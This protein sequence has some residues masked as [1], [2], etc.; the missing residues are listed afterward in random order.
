[1]AIN[2]GLR[3]IRRLC[4]QQETYEWYKSKLSPLLFKP[5]EQPVFKW[6]DDF[7]RTHHALP[8]IDTLVKYFPAVADV[9]ATEVASYYVDLLEND[10]C[11]SKIVQ[12]GQDSANLLKEN[13][14]AWKPAAEIL[15][16]TLNDISRQ[17]YREKIMDFGAEAN[18]LLTKTYYGLEKVPNISGFGWPYMDEM[19]GAMPGDVVS[20]IGRP[21]MGKSWLTLYTALHNWQV[22]K[23]SVLFVSMEMSH[24]P[25]AQRAAT[26]IAHTNLTQLKH[27][28]HSDKGYSTQTEKLFF[29]SMETI[30]SPIEEGGARL[31]IVDGNL[32]ADMEDIFSL[33]DQLGCQTVIIDGAYLCRHKNGRLDRFTRAAENCESMKRYSNDLMVASF[34]SW[35]FNRQAADKQKKKGGTAEI[36]LEDIGYSDAIP[37]ISSIVLGLFQEDGVET[38]TK[39]N[40]RVMKGR[41]GEVGEF[42][43]GWD[44][45]TMNFDQIG[46]KTEDFQNIYI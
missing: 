5:N 25:I 15:R 44:F 14:A 35:Q 3:V 17:Q 32:A 11:F 40:I 8:Q 19:G 20:F 39:K 6:V 33:A 23:H 38:M 42:D 2:L 13:N 36:G 9:P 18:S 34:A 28:H 37:Q 41:G 21:Q 22:R 16:R 30:T 12:C 46:I 43:I 7:V 1:M 24:L 4:E 45:N 26:M 31:Y 29:S 27:G 10:Y